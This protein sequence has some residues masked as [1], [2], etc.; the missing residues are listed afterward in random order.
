MTDRRQWVDVI[1]QI[2]QQAHDGNLDAAVKGLKDITKELLPHLLPELESQLK[3]QVKP[4][5]TNHRKRKRNAPRRPQNTQAIKTVKEQIERIKWIATP[6]LDPPISGAGELYRYSCGREDMMLAFW[7]RFLEDGFLAK[8]VR[9]FFI[10]DKPNA[11]S[12]DVVRRILGELSLH[13]ENRFLLSSIANI[14]ASVVEFDEKSSLPSALVALKAAT[15]EYLQLTEA[16]DLFDLATSGL[17]SSPVLRS[18]QV[19]PLV[20]SIRLSASYWKHSFSAVF[21]AFAKTFCSLPAKF[22]KV[23]VFF[24]LIRF[25]EADTNQEKTNNNDSVFNWQLDN[26]PDNPLF[27][28]PPELITQTTLQHWLEKC[29][30]DG[31]QKKLWLEELVQRHGRGPWDMATL[32]PYVE[33]IIEVGPV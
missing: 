9:H 13:Y 31:L 16:I 6:M 4:M 7:R 26:L 2:E 28:P 14:E 3:F 19:I 18:Y 21:S 22:E 27:L 10:E 12:F 5:G 32:S 1:S 29:T 8:P 24:Y 23:F 25:V 15:L 30:T 20:I 11:E 17:R 33:K